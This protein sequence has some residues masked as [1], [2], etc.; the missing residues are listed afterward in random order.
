MESKFFKDGHYIYECKTS[1]SQIGGYF[2][3]FYLKKSIKNLRNRFDRDGLPEGYRYVFPVNHLDDEGKLYIESL[4]DDYPNI[5]IRYYEQDK[6][7]KLIQNLNKVNTLESLVA[8]IESI[9]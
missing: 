8:Y 1:P 9:R 4:Q 6:V 3:N 5:D 2:N 7:D